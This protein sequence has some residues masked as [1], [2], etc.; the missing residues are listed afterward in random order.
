MC[1]QW[2]L[3]R[4]HSVGK[5]ILTLQE[6]NYELVLEKNLSTTNYIS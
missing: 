2:L 4:Q 6:G 1:V 3:M 5:E